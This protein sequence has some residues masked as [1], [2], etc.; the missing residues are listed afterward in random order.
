MDIV[1][2]DGATRCEPPICAT[3]VVDDAACGLRFASI[4]FVKDV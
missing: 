1:A 4:N 2:N 3:E